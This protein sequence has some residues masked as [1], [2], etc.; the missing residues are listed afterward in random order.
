MTPGQGSLQAVVM[1]GGKGSRMTELTCTK[2][3]C[4][5]PVAGQPM[6]YWPLNTLQIN[7][8]T[9]AIVIVP[10][11]AKSEAREIFCTGSDIPTGLVSLGLVLDFELELDKLGF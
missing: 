8:F 2:A 4:L 5:L 11:S 1:A 3:K 6:L 10:D 7:G 9:E